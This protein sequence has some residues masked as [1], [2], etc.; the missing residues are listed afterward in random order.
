ML[1]RDLAAAGHFPAINVGASVS[2]VMTE[3]TDDAHQQAARQVR[4]AMAVYEEAR[5]LITIGAYKEGNQPEL[6]RAVAV[7]SDI[8]GFLAQPIGEQADWQQTVGTLMH[9]GRKAEG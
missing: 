1:S 5:D 8:K 7:H 3:A 4:A 6:D 9:L 2:R